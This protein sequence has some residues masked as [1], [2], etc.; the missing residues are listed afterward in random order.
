MKLPVPL[1]TTHPWILDVTVQ[2]DALLGDD[3]Q[4]NAENLGT[5]A[6]WLMLQLVA[7]ADGDPAPAVAVINMALQFQQTD[8]LIKHYLQTI[9]R[10]PK[11]TAH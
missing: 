1:D 6:L 8:D 9:G 5:V 11:P 7:N 3:A 2:L 10:E 4:T